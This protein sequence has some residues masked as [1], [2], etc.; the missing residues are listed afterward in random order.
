MA[1]GGLHNTSEPIGKLSYIAEYGARLGVILKE[2]LDAQ[3]SWIDDTCEAI[4]ANDDARITVGLEPI[5]PP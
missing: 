4:G 1:I 2:E 5:R 3:P